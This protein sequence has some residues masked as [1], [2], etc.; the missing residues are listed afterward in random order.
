MWFRKQNLFASR[1]FIKLHANELT[2]MRN[3]INFDFWKQKPNRF[4]CILFHS[5]FG[6]VIHFTHYSLTPLTCQF[7]LLFESIEFTDSTESTR[8][9]NCLLLLR[10]IFR[11]Q[12]QFYQM[13]TYH[14]VKA[15]IIRLNLK[16][17]NQI[18]LLSYFLHS[19]MTSVAFWFI[20]IYSIVDTSVASTFG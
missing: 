4:I 17:N 8:T 9:L 10:K 1:E 15:C 12:S 6:V 7:E 18:T 16:F 19:T 20:F 2:D 11:I 5:V 14:Q 3:L 13:F